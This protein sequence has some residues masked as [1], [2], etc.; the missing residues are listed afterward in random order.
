MSRRFRRQLDKFYGSDDQEQLKERIN[1]ASRYFTDEL[2]KII[3][4]FKSLPS[5]ATD[6]Y[7]SAEEFRFCLESL[8]EDLMRKRY[9]IRNIRRDFSTD[10]VLKLQREAEVPKLDI[11]PYRSQ[12]QSSRKTRKGFIE[13]ILDEAFEAPRRRKKKD[14]DVSKKRPKSDDDRGQTE[15]QSKRVRGETYEVTYKMYCS[16]KSLE[17]I[18]EERGLVPSTIETHLARLI[19]QG[20]VSVFDFVTQE[21]LDAVRDS[22]EAGLA[23]KD[24]FEALEGNISYG[25]LR[26]MEAAIKGGDKS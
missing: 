9:V 19:G 23:L 12:R 18:A 17:R 8:Y 24:I 16:G 10:H 7:E 21:Q 5:A 11:K 15:I 14:A 26:M 1:A 2:D 4:L 13:E 20:R 6:D 3:K 25:Q 22:L